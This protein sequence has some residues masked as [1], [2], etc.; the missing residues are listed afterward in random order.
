MGNS[1]NMQRYS[2]Y[3]Q[4]KRYSSVSAHSKQ[5]LHQQNS[6]GRHYPEN[7]KKIRPA[8]A[9]AVTFSSCRFA[10]ALARCAYRLR[11]LAYRLVRR[12]ACR[13]NEFAAEGQARADIRIRVRS[14]VI[15][16]RIRHTAIRVRIVVPAIDHTA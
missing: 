10:P 1:T 14:I 15:R 9:G 11:H 8:Y 5:H 6:T 2:Y 12:H 16:I 3:S 7:S 4:V 13:P